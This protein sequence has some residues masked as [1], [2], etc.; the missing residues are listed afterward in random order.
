[1]NPS[2]PR[3]DTQAPARKPG[4]AQSLLCFGGNFLISLTDPPRIEL[5][6]FTMIGGPVLGATEGGRTCGTD[7]RNGC[8]GKI[9]ATRVKYLAG[10]K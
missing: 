6:A 10:I 3:S 7:P 9:S 1:M 2:A 5:G 4:L 8:H